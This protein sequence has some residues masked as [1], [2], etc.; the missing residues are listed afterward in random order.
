MA[1]NG[2]AR[3][4]AS[5]REQEQELAE[6]MH[7]NFI[8]FCRGKLTVEQVKML[9]TLPIGPWAWLQHVM[10]EEG[11]ETL[12]DVYG[13]AVLL[14]EKFSSNMTATD[15]IQTIRADVLKPRRFGNQRVA[16][17]PKR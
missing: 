8:D 5:E 11:L 15:I 3:V 4:P 13:F 10:K 12:E 6:W 7:E 9:N 14:R 1:A 2:G 17:A 16:A